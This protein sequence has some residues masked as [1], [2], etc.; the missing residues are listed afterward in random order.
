MTKTH[1]RTPVLA[2]HPCR[3]AIDVSRAGTG[4]W[5]WGVITDISPRGM[6]VI[7]P[8]VARQ[9]GAI[10]VCRFILGGREVRLAARQISAHILARRCFEFLE[11]SGDVAEL[12]ARHSSDRVQAA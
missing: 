11:Q 1:V 9:E 8:P 12:L 7:L 3:I 2:T 6:A 5:T 4:T 10:F